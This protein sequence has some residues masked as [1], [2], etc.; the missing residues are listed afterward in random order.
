M[1]GE[2]LF[3]VTLSSLRG[4]RYGLWIVFGGIRIS[5]YLRQ[6]SRKQDQDIATVSRRIIS[7]EVETVDQGRR[8]KEVGL[9]HPTWQM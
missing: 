1:S 4:C 5:W 6:L 2:L 3:T 9:V 7:E 8:S